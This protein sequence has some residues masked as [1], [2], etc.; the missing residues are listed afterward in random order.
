MK[1]CEIIQFLSNHITEEL[2]SLAFVFGSIARNNPTPSDCDLFI[3]TPALPGSRLWTELKEML[4]KNKSEFKVKF[5][6]NLNICVNTL[7]EYYE[8]SD[9]KDRIMKRPRIIIKNGI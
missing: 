3:V 9:F 2:C 4:E 6:I 7:Q 8:G 5:G 1:N